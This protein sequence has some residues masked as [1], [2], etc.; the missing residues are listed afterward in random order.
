MIFETT[1]EKWQRYYDQ[2]KARYQSSTLETLEEI[3]RQSE[4][5]MLREVVNYAAAYQVSLPKADGAFRGTPGRW[6]SFN[7]QLG[8]RRLFLEGKN[9]SEWTNTKEELQKDRE[10]LE[11]IKKEQSKWWKTTNPEEP[12]ERTLAKQIEEISSRLRE[13][14]EKIESCRGVEYLL[15][16]IHQEN[17][18]PIISQNDQQSIRIPFFGSTRDAFRK[19][20]TAI[21]SFPGVH[22][23]AWEKL[24]EVSREAHSPIVTSCIF[25][26]DE[27]A[28]GYGQHDLK[29]DRSCYC[30][31]LY[32]KQEEWACHWFTMWRE[33][34]FRAHSKGCN[35]LV[36]TKMNGSLGKSQEGEVRWLDDEKLPYKRISIKDFAEMILSLPTK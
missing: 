22:G 16:K 32:G 18:H 10:I 36:V 23:Y 4:Q 29:P 19:G 13:V 25:L 1:D 30:M 8:H 27:K 35:L 2:Y 15:P 20:E 33:Q 9:S 11:Q 14:E 12:R 17:M 21:V 3:L 5:A 7:R 6:A 31:D 28:P 24:T 26:P 34:T